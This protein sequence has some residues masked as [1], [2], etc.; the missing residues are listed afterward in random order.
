MR[1]RVVLLVVAWSV[2]VIV[3]FRG[4]RQVQRRSAVDQV[5]DAVA[6]S[7][8]QLALAKSEGVVGADD[9]G[10]QA[11]ECRCVAQLA[12]DQWDA[13]IETLES[14]LEDTSVEGWLPNPMLAMAVATDRRQHGRLPRAVRLLRRATAA[15]P[16]DPDL[17]FF[18][19]QSRLEIEQ[20]A[21]VLAQ[22]RDRL[23][24]TGNA[25]PLLR[26]RLAQ[27]NVDHHH[28]DAAK[29]LLGTRP[30]ADSEIRREWFR[31]RAAMF[32]AA[33]DVAGLARTCREW[34]AA[35]GA[36]ANVL[37]WHALTLSVNGLL[38]PQHQLLPMLEAAAAQRDQLDDPMVVSILLRRLVRSLVIHGRQ[39]DALALF[40]E[41]NQEIDLG[42]SREELVRSRLQQEV[43]ETVLAQRRG[44]LLF[45]APPSL[46]AAVLWLSADASA[47]DSDFEPYPVPA[48]GRLEVGR[49][50]GVAPQRWVLRDGAERVMASG[51]VWPVQGQT[52]AIE[53]EAR[54]PQEIGRYQAARKA[55]DGRQRVFT[56]VLDC[57]DWRLV[58]YGRARGDLPVLDD[59]I[60]RGYR[61]VLESMPPFTAT[62][63]YDL[64]SPTRRSSL[65]PI[66]VMHM[67][68]AELAGNAFVDGNPVAALSWFL[69]T[70]PTLFEALGAGEHVVV[71]MLYSEGVVQA[72]RQAEMRGPGGRTR[73]F[74]QWRTQR[75]LD[76]E[77]R[78]LFAEL[79]AQDKQRQWVEEAAAAL[80]AAVEIARRGEADLLLLR[81]ASLDLMTHTEFDNISASAQD[82]GGGPLYAFYRYLD[83]RI[84]ELESHLDEDD[85]LI[86][87]SDH[88]IRTSMEHDTRCVFIAAGAGVPH[89]RLAG[90]PHLRGIPRLLA[91][92]LG[93]E[94]DWPSTGIEAW[95]EPLKVES[96]ARL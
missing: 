85:I 83:R 96:E 48:D 50:A 21:L 44:L 77:E 4:W 19:L 68:G 35:G 47:P 87:M 6:E 42:L 24:T 25:A 95:A 30:P 79:V 94:T 10:R 60:R 49:S 56:I 84:G 37:A 39:D 7:N 71:N 57:A 23:P 46:P 63:M 69:P 2:A 82:D 15:Y 61:A 33:N 59:L 75:A 88:G 8:W 16:E 12:S 73:L 76:Q 72:G 26:I 34:R 70:S 45:E 9:L 17:F 5:C 1:I 40:D 86:I 20:P 22:M 41:V 43:S 55:G 3:G 65:S 67:L 81:V 38:D 92:L 54:E 74:T 28:I 53:I 58:Q 27:A 29:Q 78:R 31:V 62:A 18:E 11:A 14:L 91:D 93:V 52:L 80:D 90:M 66:G 36:P 89:G 51:A 64:V 13:C 32:G